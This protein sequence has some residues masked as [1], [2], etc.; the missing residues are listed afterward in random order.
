MSSEQLLPPVVEIKAAL[1][2]VT[3]R[4]LHAHADHSVLLMLFW[5]KVHGEQMSYRY[6]ARF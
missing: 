3:P 4:A 6:I 5:L 2:V 1:F